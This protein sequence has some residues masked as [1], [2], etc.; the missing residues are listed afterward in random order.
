VA[1]SNLSLDSHS[2]NFLR[3]P[4]R[5]KLVTSFDEL[6]STRFRDGINALCWRRELVGDFGEVV[7]QLRTT[8]DVAEISDD[9][10]AQLPLSAAG[11]SARAQLLEDLRALRARELA[12]VLNCIRRYPVEDQ[13]GAV[14]TDV[15]SFHV[16]SAPV[17]A[18]TWLCTYFGAASEGLCNEEA[19]KRVENPATRAALMEEF[20]RSGGIG[21]FEEFL[22][23]HCYDLHYEPTEGAEPYSFGL[24]HLWRIAAQYPGS[25]VPP[26]IHRAPRT[27]E[28]DPRRLLLIS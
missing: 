17:E 13:P 20:R 27:R 7:A 1:F 14:P 28:G 16:D 24:G 4:S 5:T 15:H 8:E 6:V 12:P 21:T 10:L 19:R 18:D 3:A 9:K 22:G 26:C 2:S 23:D 11:H 25:P